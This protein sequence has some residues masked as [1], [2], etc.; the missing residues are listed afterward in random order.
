MTV[1][2]AGNLYI[3]DTN[4]HRIRKIDTSGVITTVAGTGVVGDSGDD[5]AATTAQLNSPFN[6]TVDSAGN[7]YIADTNNHRIRKIDTSGVITTVA[8][9]GVSGDSGDDG[10]ATTAQL[11]LSYMA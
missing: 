3:A 1:D 7:L 6:V 4:N 11:E 5:G 8:G 10:V 9:T 2:S